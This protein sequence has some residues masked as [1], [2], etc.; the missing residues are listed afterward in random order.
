[1]SMIMRYKKPGGFKQLLKL[2]ETSG[3]G[4]QEKFL[5]IVKDEDSVWAATI[6][7]KMLTMEKILSWNES[8]ISE[9]FSRLNDL[10]ISLCSF[11]LTEDQWKSATRTFSHS[12]LR[13]LKDLFHGKT[14]SVAEQS[15][16]IVNVLTEVRTMIDDGVIKLD[17]VDE[18]LV[19]D[20][21]IEDILM[22]NLGAQK[23]ELSV[24][25]QEV[26]KLQKEIIVESVEDIQ[27]ELNKLRK[28][29]VSLGTENHNLRRE[30]EEFRKKLLQIKKLSA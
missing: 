15:T 22:Q 1:M 20:D 4:K 12:R 24:V 8:T 25:P 9:I 5:A 16:A 11:V 6:E 7:Q 21:K 3:K 13:N 28:K 10:T 18:N 29:I 23:V 2:I 19:I 26:K 14:P 27:T 30:N 17:Q